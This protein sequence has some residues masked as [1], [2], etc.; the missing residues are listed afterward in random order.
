MTSQ[1]VPNPL[2]EGAPPNEHKMNAPMCSP[3]ATDDKQQQQQMLGP[4]IDAAT[5][6]LYNL[7]NFQFST[8][9]LTSAIASQL[10]EVC[11]SQHYNIVEVWIHDDNECY[12]LAHSYYVRCSLE[13]PL[14]SRIS[15]VYRNYIQGS[16]AFSHRLSCAL[17][18]WAKET[19]QIFRVSESNYPQ[20]LP[21]VALKHSV[22]GVQT[23]VAVYQ[24]VREICM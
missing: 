19:K 22:S 20:H 18:K 14:F 6:Y 13:Q 8:C 23:A 9:R 7:N 21:H 2:C 10:S 1:P 24:F 12:H 17:C 5:L 4:Q 3:G 15:N 11:E 16:A